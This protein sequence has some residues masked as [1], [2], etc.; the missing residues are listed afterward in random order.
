MEYEVH[1]VKKHQGA[2]ELCTTLKVPYGLVTSCC[3][4]LLAF[5]QS[6]IYVSPSYYICSLL[7]LSA[8]HIRESHVE[9]SLRQR[10]LQWH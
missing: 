1:N 3:S 10:P 6:N 4:K 8:S 5:V 9:K 7:V 2:L